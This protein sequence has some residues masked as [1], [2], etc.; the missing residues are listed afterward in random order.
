MEITF[1]FK[2]KRRT[3]IDNYLKSLNDALCQ[4]GLFDDDSQIDQILVKRGEIIRLGK[5]LV[6]IKSLTDPQIS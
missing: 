5:T 3:D 2:D 6:K 1:H 4:A